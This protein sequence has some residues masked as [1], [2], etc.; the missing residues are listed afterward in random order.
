[1]KVRGVR[2]IAMRCGLRLIHTGGDDMGTYIVKVKCELYLDV[3]ADSAIDAERIVQAY[4]PRITGEDIDFSKYV[5][6]TVRDSVAQSA[7]VRRFVRICDLCGDWIHGFSEHIC[8]KC[9]EEVC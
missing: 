8:P 7:K 3:D 4:K 1:M 9:K 6:H 2:Y 5:S